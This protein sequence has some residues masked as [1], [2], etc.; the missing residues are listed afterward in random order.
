[1]GFQ[2]GVS[3]D[4]PLPRQPILQTYSAVN[5]GGRRRQLVDTKLT[6]GSRCRCGVL[7]GAGQLVQASV[8]WI[9]VV[10]YSIPRDSLFKASLESSPDHSREVRV[11]H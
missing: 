5:T 3:S 2:S 4:L 9:L 10:Y 11:F 7:D 6:L 1:M 8:D